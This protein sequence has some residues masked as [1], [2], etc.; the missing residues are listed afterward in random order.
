M[1]VLAPENRTVQHPLVK[2]AAEIGWTLLPANEALNMRKGESGMLLRGVLRERLLALNPGVV[3]EGNVDEIIGKLDSVR[4]DIE[5]NAE[6]L[7][8]LRGKKSV[9]VQADKRQRNV[10]L[11]DFQQPATNVFH[12]STEWDYT[13]GQHTN[14]ADV[15]FVINGVPVALVETKRQGRRDALDDG[16]KQV[17]RY[18]SETPELV[19]TPQVFD[20]NQ[21]VDFYYGPTWNLDRKAL[22][23]WKDE[24]PGNFERKVKAFFDHARFLRML[25]EWIVFFRKDDEL[26]KIV[27]RQHQT[28][29]VG[30]V[31]ERAFDE[32][33]R[34]GLVWH[35][36]GSDKTFT[37]IKVAELVLRSAGEKPTVLMLVDRNELQ[38]QLF[39]NLRSYGLDYEVATSKE[40]LRELLR[41]DQ[42]GLIVSMI[43]KF[44]K[45][46]A[47]LC[48]R[49]NV[50]VLIDEAHRSTGGDLGNY[51]V[52]ALPKATLIG[53]TGTP[54]DRTA[55]G[56][57]TFK[58][59][60]VDDKKGYLDKYS[61]KESIED[62]TTLPL[63]YSLA[64]ND[65]RV[66]RDQL[67]K[68]FLGLA[69]AEGIA[70]IDELNR[71]LDRAV[72]LKNFLKGDDRVAKVAAFVAEHFRTNVDPLG[73]KAFLVGVDREACALYK[74]ALDKHLPADWST[75]V[76]T[77]AHNDEAPL[78][79]YRLEDAAEKQVRKL[80]AKPGALPKILI[81]TEKLLTGFDAPILYCMY[82]DKPMRDHTLLQ[83]IARVNRPWE[84]EAGKR[85]PSGF[86]VD[87][88]GIFEKL[89]KA[90]AFDADEVETSIVEIGVLKDRFAEIM[91]HD[92]QPYL[93]LCRKPLDDKGVE[94]I[95]EHFSDPNRRD[96]FFKFFEETQEL[97]EVLSPDA[98][99]RP[100]IDD[101]GRLAGVQELL[102][103]SFGHK[104]FRYRDLAEKTAL[105]VRERVESYGLRAA[106]APVSIDE[107]TLDALKSD[108]D[109]KASRV[110][111][112]ARSLKESVEKAR[113]EQPFLVPIADRTN[114]VLERFSDRQISTQEAL[115][116]LKRL[117]EEFLSAQAEQKT[118]G[119]Q[120]SA[121]TVYWA[122][123]RDGVPKARGL[124]VALDAAFRRSSS[125]RDDA[126]AMRNLKAEVYKLLLPAV[127][128]GKMV[129]L[130]DRLI[131]LWRPST[132]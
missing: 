67:E 13:N 34:R 63:R 98:F 129:D 84:N 70:D 95:L 96:A 102:E 8:W 40:R 39:D 86:V 116:Q 36:Q 28:R 75:V 117:V 79:H 105:L 118:S 68:E 37:M 123:K 131:Y 46:D 85:K 109:P 45:A 89:N 115:L 54:I 41:K 76:Y 27:L 122:L 65:I 44:D 62:G 78:T 14:R 30:K 9:S 19:A 53:F 107:K 59:F 77:S 2:Y 74:Q 52:G 114:A 92:A 126:E 100:F 111:N 22:F 6:I 15:M 103:D 132:P 69:E 57:G 48:T 66:P 11:I 130:A 5:G 99:L 18:H 101:Y 24:E 106:T 119:L 60:G 56:G 38:A 17:R 33:R 29:A 31:V 49:D 97:Y 83:A 47:N 71:I 104:D 94:R 81:V 121:F 61:M 26:R 80:F 73:Y 88:V 128:K 25:G 23:N 120:D 91:R 110:L 93:K 4:A 58:T 32:E 12:V 3:N 21:I 112:L 82:L 55:H 125:F 72:N 16:F 108:T 87:F 35:T 10:I 90:L 113:A 50:I 43:H 20:V 124:A 1:P 51:L 42:R 64:P 7:D 127:G